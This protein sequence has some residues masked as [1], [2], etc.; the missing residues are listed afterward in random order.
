MWRD[1]FA[2]HWRGLLLTGLG[3]AAALRLAA[4]GRLSWYVHPRYEWFTVSMSL[5]GALL[6][7]LSAWAVAARGRAGSGG[8]GPEGTGERT[9]PG[10]TPERAGPEGTGGPDPHPHEGPDRPAGR[11]ATAGTVALAAAAAV[12]LLVLP[13][14]QLSAETAAQR[15]VTA[16]GPGGPAGA[17]GRAAV[18]ADGAAV[19]GAELTVKDW[20][21]LLRQNS[22]ADAE[23]RSASLLGFVVADPEDPAARFHVAR[24]LVSCCAVDAQPVGVPVLLP[25]WQDTVAEGDWVRVDGT[26]VLNPDVTSAEQL[27]LAPSGVTPVEAPEDPYVY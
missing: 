22:G 19:D 10:G 1:A 11:A 9:E 24:F 18:A 4:T 21:M 20:S 25:G 12:A 17:D 15:Q 6:V 27:L 3:V 5:L 23:G 16:A 8:T 26:F 13:P 14:A 2:R 7:V